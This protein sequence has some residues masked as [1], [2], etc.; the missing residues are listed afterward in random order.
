MSNVRVSE[1]DKVRFLE[2]IAFGHGPNA[3]WTWISG[4]DKAGYGRFHWCRENIPAQRFVCFAWKD[5]IPE[6]YHTDHLCRNP[7]CV[8]PQHLEAVPQWTNTLRGL[9][10]VAKNAAKECCKSGHTFDRKNT[11]WYRG[12]RHCRECKRL[13]EAKRRQRHAART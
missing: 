5:G 6:T 8:N 12:A 13:C 1:S 9:S 7:C 10:P 11:Y 2:K 3:C 4:L